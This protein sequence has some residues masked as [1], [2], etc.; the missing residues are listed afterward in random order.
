[1]EG[2]TDMINCLTLDMLVSYFHVYWDEEIGAKVQ[3]PILRMTIPFFKLLE[4]IF[5]Y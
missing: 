3:A 1:M 4:C 2:L 5:K